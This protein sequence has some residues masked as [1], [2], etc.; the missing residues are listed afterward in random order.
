MAQLVIQTDNQAFIDQNISVIVTININQIHSEISTQDLEVNLS[1]AG[2]PF[3]FNMTDFDAVALTCNKTVDS[4]WSQPLPKLLDL[5]AKNVNITMLTENKL[6]S[7]DKK[8]RTIYLK[9]KDRLDYLQGSGCLDGFY[10]T[11]SFSVSSL[12]HTEVYQN[13]TIPIQNSF[14]GVKIS[15][16]V[17]DDIIKKL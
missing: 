17:N 1:F 6:V 13:I 5:E 14:P 4:T 2:K 16:K 9:G 11:I 3:G 7:F 15:N 10:M 8:T 12:K